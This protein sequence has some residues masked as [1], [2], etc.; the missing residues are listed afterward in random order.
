MRF[1]LLRKT[2]EY[3]Q[4]RKGKEKEEEETLAQ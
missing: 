2:S 4:V 1:F 3:Q